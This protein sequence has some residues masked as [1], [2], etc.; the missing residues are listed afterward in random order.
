VC[1]ALPS[2][3][4]QAGCR[5][6]KKRKSD[7]RTEQQKHLPSRILITIRLPNV[8]WLDGQKKHCTDQQ[9]RMPNPLVSNAHPFGNKVRITITKQQGDLEEQHASRPNQRHSAEPRQNKFCNHWLDLKQQK[10]AYENS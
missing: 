2:L 8:T 4:Q 5:Q 7:R 6:W 10:C 1:L 3:N 9:Y